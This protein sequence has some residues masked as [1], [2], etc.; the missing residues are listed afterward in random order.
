[1]QVVVWLITLCFAGAVGFAIGYFEGA[2][3]ERRRQRGGR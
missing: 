1:M 2:R 3:D